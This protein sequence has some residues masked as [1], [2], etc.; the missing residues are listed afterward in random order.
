MKRSIAAVFILCLSAMA[1]IPALSAASGSSVDYALEA[2]DAASGRPLCVLHGKNLQRF[3]DYALRT[4]DG[5]TVVAVPD[6][7]FLAKDSLV[8]GLPKETAAG[9]YRLDLVPRTQEV[10][11]VPMTVQ[12][13]RPLPGS[14]KAQ[15]LDPALLSGLSTYATKADLALLA[16]KADLDAI[17]APNLSAYAEK[18]LKGSRCRV[19][20]G[21]SIA[22]SGGFTAI[23]FDV[24]D[25]DT[26]GCRYGSPER[27]VCETPGYYHVTAKVLLPTSLYFVELRKNGTTV[28]QDVVATSI[29]GGSC[30]VATSLHLSKDDYLEVHV[31]ANSGNAFTVQAGSEFSMVK[32]GE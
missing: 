24:D 29:Y 7:V 30:S 9:L 1:A 13:G 15:D 10:L 19:S 32:V 20:A 11:S 31:R 23:P 17:Q 28:A 4:Q 6:V 3:V 21:A 5:T 14:I 18:A 27:L 8:L 22:A 25:F 26:D 12:N 2:R 16:T